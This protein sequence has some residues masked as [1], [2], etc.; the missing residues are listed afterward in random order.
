MEYIQK[1]IQ[2]LS[3]MV[4]DEPVISSLNSIRPVLETV[5]ASTFGQDRSTRSLASDIT[6]RRRYSR[7]HF[8]FGII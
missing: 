5:E 2:A 8:P 4:A 7:M 3:D 6:T 1:A